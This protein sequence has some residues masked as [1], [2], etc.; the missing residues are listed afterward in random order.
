MQI[1]FAGTVIAQEPDFLGFD[2]VQGFRL[3]KR[4]VNQTWDEFLRGA[5]AI[6]QS[7]SPNRKRI[8]SGTITPAPADSQAE[9]LLLLGS[10]YDNLPDKGVLI[11]QI[12]TAVI[13]YSDAV[14]QSPEEL[15]DPQG[16]SYGFRLSFAVGPGVQSRSVT[17]GQALV[18]DAG[19][20]IPTDAGATVTLNPIH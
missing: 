5:D 9:A 10:T 13:T 20:P 6:P 18:T 4:Q 7:R 11:V 17:T 19:A 8:L 14:L 12:G 3:P 15:E 1:T 2:A 16:F